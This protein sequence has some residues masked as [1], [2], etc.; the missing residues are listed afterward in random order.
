MSL[1]QVLISVTLNDLVRR[2]G[3]YFA[4]F[5]RTP[6]LWAN[7]VKVVEDKRILSETKSVVQRI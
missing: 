4:L 2:N 6:Q 1:L 7:Y 3:R 5:Y